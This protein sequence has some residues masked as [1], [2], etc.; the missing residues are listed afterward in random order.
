M[1]RSSRAQ[2]NPVPHKDVGNDRVVGQF[3]YG[4][5]NA[6]GIGRFRAHIRIMA[7]GAEIYLVEVST[8]DLVRGL[9]KKQLWAVSATQEQA[10]ALVLA[11]VPEG[12]SAV[13]TDGRLKPEE[14]ALLNMHTGDVR[15]LTK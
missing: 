12:W 3:N 6:L 7:F 10:V 15:E 1:A 8:D 11:A 9:P 4:R 2:K 5:R 14:V 13:L